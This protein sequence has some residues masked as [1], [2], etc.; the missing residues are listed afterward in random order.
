MAF[1]II[2][3]FPGRYKLQISF[4]HDL[5]IIKTYRLSLEVGNN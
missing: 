5:S 1:E 4:E 3:L 2:P